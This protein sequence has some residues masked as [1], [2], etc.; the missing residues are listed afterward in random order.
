MIK[1]KE[2]IYYSIGATSNGVKTDAF[3][4]FLLF[5]YSNI[6]GLSP[7]LASLV[8]FLALVIDAVS[9]PIIGIISDRTN[10]QLGRRHPF[11][12]IGLIPMT[13]SYFFLFSI[14]QSWEFSQMHI[15]LWMLTFTVF[16]RLGM[17]LFDVPHRS[18]GGEL[19]N[20]YS[21]RTNIF[22]WRE[23]FL[24][25]GGLTNAFLAYSVFF[26]NNTQFKNG[27]LNPE[28]WTYYGLTGSLIMMA[29]VL[30]TY[31]GTLKKSKDINKFHYSFTIRQIFNQILNAFRT[32]S[33]ILFFL[34]Y[35]FIAL[36]WGLSSSLQL[37][38]TTF[39]WEFDTSKLTFF[40]P[41]YASASV[42]AFYILSLVSNI[43]EKRTL[44]LFALLIASIMHAIPVPLAL[45]GYLP[46][47]G[48]WNLFFA[49]APFLLVT[50]TCLVASAIIRESM[51]GDISDE[52]ELS[53]GL[54]QQGLMY[55][56]SSFIG[57]LN[58]GFGILL[59]GLILE[60]INFPQGS[61]ITPTASQIINLALTQGPLVSILMFI[62][63]IIFYFY[64]ISRSKHKEILNKLKKQKTY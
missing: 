27:L 49:T 38:V 1:R 8:I 6:I 25:A 54:G 22:A 40:I 47:L 52:V 50:S 26:R 63:F 11:F 4:Y 51:L 57:K 20:S 13:F 28:P 23:L 44:I 34:G 31:Y 45:L 15:F 53:S 9:D 5:F 30:I 35:L 17:T 36:S 21:E 39:F 24:V 10:H 46:S 16:T 61:E 33:F 12:L 14:Q 7:G 62:P 41:I 60:F 48:S 2:K 42:L 59:S 18:F 19:S 3:T 58:T 55:A 29:S 56:S 32:K 43:F 64:P 37:Y